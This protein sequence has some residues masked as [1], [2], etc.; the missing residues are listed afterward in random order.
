MGYISFYILFIFLYYVI[1]HKAAILPG[2]E[3]AI[4]FAFVTCCEV[5][6]EQQLAGAASDTPKER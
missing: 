3:C 4:F 2:C 1:I 5:E 6:E